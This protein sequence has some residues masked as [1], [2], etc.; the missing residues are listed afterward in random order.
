MHN[1]KAARTS[2][3][4]P[5]VIGT[6]LSLAGL[7]CAQREGE[8]GTQSLVSALTSTTYEAE[9]LARTASAAGSKVT[10][11]TGASAGAYV[12]F[13][14]TAAIG[15][16]IQFS[17][18]SVAGGTYD[19]AML[20]KSNTNR[21]IVQA[22]I[23]GV[24]Q[25]T[26]C[27]EYAAS[28]AFQV[29]CNLGTATLSSSNHLIRF[30]VVGKRSSSTSFLEVI[31]RISLTASGGGTGGAGTGGANTGGAGTGGANTGGAGTG[32]AST[33][34]AG[35]GGAGTGGAGTGGANTGG[36]GGASTGGS[37]GAG[38]SVG[39]ATYEAETLTRAAS[40]AGSKVTSETGASAG[41][42]V[43]FTS[44]TPAVGDWIEFTLPNVAAGT[45][46]VAMLYKSNTNRAIVQASIDG[47]DQGPSCDQYA[48]SPA[49]QVP[50]SLGTAT[51]SSG[52]HLIRF[53]VTG[54]RSSSTSYLEV[55]DQISLTA[56][57][58]GTGGAGAGGGGNGGNGGNGGGAAG[59]GNVYTWKNVAIGGGGFVSGIV[60]SPVQSGLAYARTDVG[61]F[62]RW[63]GA[64][65]S[66]T[67]LN[68]A[69]PASQG[70][71]L[72]GES[73]AADPVDA[74]I[75]YAAAG[76][77][78]SNGNGVILRSTDQGNTWT[79]NNI[80]VPMGGNEDGRGM[81]E[82]LAVDPNNNTILY[83]GSRTAGL[84][85]STNSGTSWAQVTGFPTTGDA[86]FGLPVVVFDKAG[87][88]AAGSNTIYVAAAATNAGSNLYR[89]T[90]G[91]SSWALVSGGPSGLMAHHA[92][93]ASD[94][95]LWLAYSN[96]HGPY[97][98]TGV[99]LVGT[100]LEALRQL[101]DQRDAAGVELGWD[102]G[103]HQRRRARPAA[104][105]RLDARLV[106]PRPFAGN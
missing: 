52:N 98:T 10:S 47:V 36:G 38:G 104:R 86:G 8:I 83:F 26:P 69:F 14:G 57:G 58:G 20:Y 97:N 102:G 88:T 96:D 45:Y 9:T 78:R 34:G 94:G 35:T 101:L 70:N 21:A 71:Y 46:D 49:F 55:I 56:N 22:S 6:L 17:L 59:S 100:D 85:K 5:I 24:N 3:S 18:P 50:C 37:G 93:I 32:G 66:W 53:R 105:D 74:N 16:W 33:G 62:Y 51:L 90:N 72:G 80:G 27:D 63:N 48:S 40:A 12:Q 43:Q 1:R 7:T 77:Y 25:G 19:V 11:E 4:G 92:S 73:I 54:K 67:P 89:T 60:F 29:P 76:M 91:G 87:G 84:R 65:N 61:G 75:V 79:V 15:D 81:G 42:Y 2:K 99:T 106:Q 31:D 30:T 95:T 13:S 41:A 39:T 103:R 82:R 28:P 68:D 44:S 64:A 23:D